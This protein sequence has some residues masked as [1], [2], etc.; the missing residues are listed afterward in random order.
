MGKGYRNNLAKQ[1]AEHLVCTELGRRDLVAT[2]FSGNVPNYDILVA[3]SSGRALPIQVKA[4]RGDTWPTNARHWMNIELDSQTGVQKYIG[5][6]SLPTPDLVYVCVALTPLDSASRDRFFILTMA[7]LQ[8][9]C[10][11]SYK[12]WMDPHNWRRP[13]QVASFDLRYKIE[14]LEEFEDNWT[15]ISGLLQS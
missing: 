4:T 8:A 9:V 7:E 13:K 2:P 12:A 6:N 5:L 10:K 11:R 15:L 1:M 14:D 3:D